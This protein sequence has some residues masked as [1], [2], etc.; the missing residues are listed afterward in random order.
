MRSDK[1]VRPIRTRVTVAATSVTLVALIL[2]AAGVVW[3]QRLVLTARLDRQLEQ[4]SD[5]LTT[6]LATGSLPDDT[7]LF[8]VIDPNGVLIASSPGFVIPIGVPADDITARTVDGIPESDDRARILSRQVDLD[9]GHHLIHTVEPMD[10]IDEAATA[11][12]LSLA[13]AVPIV[14]GLLGGLIWSMVGATLRPV[15]A[16]R[17]EVAK[18]GLSNLSRRVPESGNDEVGRLARTMNE[19]L[20]ALERSSA[21]QRRFVADA[22]HELRTPLAR[23]RAELEVDDSH[24]ET[25]DPA[26]TVVSMIE[27]VDRLQQLV[28]DLLVLAGAESAPAAVAVVDL[29]VVVANETAGR[30]DGVLV[31]SEA[32]ASPVRG[33]PGQLARLVRNL[34]D[35]A[36]RHATTTVHVAC[37]RIGSQVVLSVTDD[38]PG[39]P[40]G[41]QDRVFDPFYRIDE[42]RSPAGGAGLGLAIV[43]EIAAAHSGSVVVDP[44][45][46][47]G[48]RLVVTFPAVD[49]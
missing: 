25:A 8:Q 14:T 41:E 49:D 18:I 23:M 12:A 11:L 7:G 48:A 17:A 37:R 16:I 27:E 22:S 10:A 20:A 19:M 44:H 34:I 1:K 26:A 29:A 6:G 35:N 40:V 9:S 5:R 38:G 39:I 36:L 45:H 21:K 3:S 15:E 28:D 2:A 32:E 30:G 47:P 33:S 24:P 31:T 46:H 4:R 13:L 43:R 42:A